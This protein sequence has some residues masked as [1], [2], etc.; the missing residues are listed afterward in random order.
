MVLGWVGLGLCRDVQDP[1]ALAA[2]FEKAEA[3][4]AERKHPDPYRRTS[5][6]SPLL[7]PISIVCFRTAATAPEGTKWCVSHSVFNGRVFTV[8]M[9]CVGSGMHL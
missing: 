2:I 5:L 9:S 8:Y 3:D 6:P 4:L 1:R 7:L